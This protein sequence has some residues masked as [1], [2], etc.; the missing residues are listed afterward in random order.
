[1]KLIHT[2]IRTCTHHTY[3][4]M[5]AKQEHKPNAFHICC[6]CRILNI[7]WKYKVTNS[8]V[9][10]RPMFSSMSS[11]LKQGRVRRLGYDVNINYGRIPQKLFTDN[12]FTQAAIFLGQHVVLSSTNVSFYLFLSTSPILSISSFVS[13]SFLN[14]RLNFLFFV[15]KRWLIVVLSV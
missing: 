7:T 1:M 4:H 8:S 11:L 5:K 15:D 13:L 12:P 6:L 10:D 2:R 9:L 3:T 14:A